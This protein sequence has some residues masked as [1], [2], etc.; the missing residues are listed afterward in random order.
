MKK[1]LGKYRKLCHNPSCQHDMPRSLPIC[2]KCGVSCTKPKGSPQSF[3]QGVIK[4][5]TPSSIVTIDDIREVKALTDR[6]G[7]ERVN[8]LCDVLK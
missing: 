4:P 1:K 6:L 2:P 8:E 5:L 7:L 3:V